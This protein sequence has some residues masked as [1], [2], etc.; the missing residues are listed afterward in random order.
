MENF[1]CPECKNEIDKNQNICPNCGYPIKDIKQSKKLFII[2]IVVAL[3]FSGIIGYM[4]WHYHMQKIEEEKQIKIEELL[5]KSKEY[6]AIADFGSVAKCYEELDSLSYDIKKESEILDYDKAVYD[7]A[8]KYY[9]SIYTVYNT[10][11]SGQYDSLKGLRDSLV[12]P[13]NE[14]D[15][16]EVNQNSLLGQY[17][18][19]VRNSV[20]YT[21]FN[22]EFIYELDYDLDYGLTSWGYEVVICT[23][24]EELLKIKCPYV[25]IEQENSDDK[26]ANVSVEEE[27]T[28]EAFVE[29]EKILKKG[30]SAYVETEYGSY[31]FRVTNV[32]VIQPDK[33]HDTSL[34]QIFWEYENI[35]FGKNEDVYLQISDWDLHVVDSDGYIVSNR[36]IFYEGDASNREGIH[37]NP[38]EKC[39]AYSVFNI[40]NEECTYLDIS[41]LEREGTTF[42]IYIEK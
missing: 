8:S 21:T 7:K 36:D 28:S 31:I 16:L 17:I 9:M 15:S 1:I 37:L 11:K 34:Y 6:Y 26:Q 33:Y 19:N 29:E 24:L 39:K 13:T 25:D 30:E 23:Y 38:N 20:V 10:I 3:F 14:F 41:I 35:D 5:S 42:R 32:T 18:E 4:T 2:L 12:T 22:S 27:V 40:N